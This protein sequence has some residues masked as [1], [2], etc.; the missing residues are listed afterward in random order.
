M[1]G[2]DFYVSSWGKDAK[3]AYT[4]AIE[5]AEYEHGNDPY[6]GTI[7]TT[8]GFTDVTNEFLN[9]G[10][11]VRTFM[12]RKLQRCEKRRCYAICLQKPVINNNKIKSVV[13][14][15]PTKGTTKWALL[16]VLYDGGHSEMSK[17]NTKTEAIKAARQHVE[18]T[19]NTVQIRME[20]R[21]LNGN[22][23]VAIIKYKKATNEKPGQWKFFG[24]AAS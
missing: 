8:D 11:D 7:S 20:K 13:E 9:S 1:G 17:Y 15:V 21:I 12:D 19:H 16:Y 18:K 3:D 23:N 22:Q 14:N 5:E 6:N 24:I 10:L 2:I 4:K